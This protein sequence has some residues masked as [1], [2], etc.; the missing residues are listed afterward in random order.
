MLGYEP[1]HDIFD[2]ENF[3]TTKLLDSTFL[4][5]VTWPC[6]KKSEK[7]EQST[8]FLNTN[9]SMSCGMGVGYPKVRN[10]SN[11]PNKKFLEAPSATYITVL[12]V[13]RERA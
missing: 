2:E 11:F 12:L 5:M 9:T 7:M 8:H 10:G 1:I 6:T 4:S 13:T 3:T